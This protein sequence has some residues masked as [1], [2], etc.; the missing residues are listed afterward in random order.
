MKNARGVQVQVPPGHR[1]DQSCAQI[2]DQNGLLKC[3][4]NSRWYQFCRSSLFADSRSRMH[5]SFCISATVETV[6]IIE[7]Y[8]LFSLSLPS[9]LSLFILTYFCRRL[10]LAGTVI[11][12]RRRIVSSN[13]RFSCSVFCGILSLGAYCSRSSLERSYKHSIVFPRE[14]WN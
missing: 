6:I 13:R 12:D 4:C 5:V 14:V 9:P 10:L 3:Q 7:L 1:S 11:F 2:S 8:F